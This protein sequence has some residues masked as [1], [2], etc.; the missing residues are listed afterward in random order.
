MQLTVS[1]FCDIIRLRATIG[2]ESLSSPSM[3]KYRRSANCWNSIF[4][5]LQDR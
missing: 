3:N 1:Q 2:S 4:T 5:S